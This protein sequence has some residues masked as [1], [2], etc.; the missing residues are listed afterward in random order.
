[1]ELEQRRNDQ[2]RVIDVIIQLSGEGLSSRLDAVRRARHSD[3]H[4]RA[5][6]NFKIT[7]ETLADIA[8]QFTKAAIRV[9]SGNQP[10]TQGAV[11]PQ[12]KFSS[13]G[14]HY[15]P[16]VCACHS[17][18]LASTTDS[19]SGRDVSVDFDT[20]QPQAEFDWVENLLDFV[21]TAASGESETSIRS[22]DGSSSILLH[23]HRWNVT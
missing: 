8:G 7:E 1:M 21:A 22:R 15:P 20:M 3:R 14:N 17:S 18:S 9:N 16:M 10:S 4:R 19:T 13:A 2:G 12:S 11:E 23:P 5:R 6:D